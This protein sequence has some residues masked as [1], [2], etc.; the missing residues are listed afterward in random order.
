MV[1]GWE[2]EAA[3]PAALWAVTLTESLIPEGKTPS[4]SEFI[5]D[6]DD[7]AVRTILSSSVLAVS[8]LV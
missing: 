6:E 2:E 1:K 4:S 7:L 3:P 5:Q 8:S